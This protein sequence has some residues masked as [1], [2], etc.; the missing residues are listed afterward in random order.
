MPIQS[1]PSR[2][3][4]RAVDHLVAVLREVRRVL[5]Q[6]E[7]GHEEAVRFARGEPTEVRVTT[8]IVRKGVR[9]RPDGIPEIFHE[10]VQMKNDV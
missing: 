7:P 10:A 3:A 4:T 5:R 8:Y 6:A 2:V 9:A 1:R